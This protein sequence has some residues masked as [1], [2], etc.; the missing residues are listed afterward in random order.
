MEGGFSLN[1]FSLNIFYCQ[2]ICT[3]I[4]LDH[5]FLQH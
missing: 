1:I 3:A 4:G 2:I 5:K